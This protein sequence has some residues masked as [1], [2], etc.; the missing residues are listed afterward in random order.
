MVRTGNFRAF[1]SLLLLLLL[2]PLTSAFAQSAKV[3][4][5]LSETDVYTGERVALKISITGKNF[6]NVSTP[7]LPDL[8]GLEYLSTSPST[9][10]NYSFING[11]I[12]RSYT[13]TYYLQADKE[14]SYTIPPV[15]V[16]IDGKTFSTDPIPVHIK[17]RNKAAESKSG[18]QRPDIY[19][20]M[21]VSNRHPVVGQQIIANVVIYFRSNLQVISYQPMAGWKAEGFWKEE[22]DNGQQPRAESTIIDGVRYRK[23]VLMKYALFASKTSTLQLS[24]YKVNCTVRYS[25]NYGDP[26]SSF[27]NGF[28]S[29]QRSVDLQTD[30]ISV[31][32]KQLPPAPTNANVLNAVGRFDISRSTDD[33][34]VRVGQSVEIKTVI[35]GSGNLAL[36][37]K[38]TYHFPSEFEVYQPQE[39]SKIDHNG[40]RIK[41]TKTFTDVIIPRKTGKFTIPGTRLAYF[42]D[43]EQ[44][45]QYVD[46]NPITVNVKANPYAGSLT[47]SESSGLAIQPLNGLVTWQTEGYR[48]VFSL[49]WMWAG[50]ALPLV[51]L[52]VGY[53][54]KQYL[55][56]LRND[57]RF[58]RSS[59]AMDTSE[60]HLSLARE[61]AQKGDL[62]EAYARLHQAVSGF[63]ADRLDLPRAGLEDPVYVKTIR[64]KGVDMDVVKRIERLLTKCSTIRY[65]PLT[66]QEDFTQDAGAA[67]ELIKSLRKW[68]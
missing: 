61:A 4:A 31:D 1:T 30:P 35:K 16:T 36:I 57:S 15:K 55:D 13:Y 63:I 62:K 37:S 5:S 6:N 23:A 19:L 49:W 24:P 40:N 9:S 51:L 58:A 45:Y 28:G 43:A 26:F 3:T 34:Q 66:S 60:Q 38:P 10:S 29:D 11:V 33:T 32:V 67:D 42:N 7:D 47:T 22:L 41:G 12:S 39:Q 46:L 64:D 21:E 65:A 17:N 54:R 18:K 48:S 8:K 56:K 20:K 50:L 27:F 59:K 44:K 68:L 52:I 53:Q 14:G 25:S 2:V